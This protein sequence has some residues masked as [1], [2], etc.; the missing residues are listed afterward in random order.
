MQLDELRGALQ[1][2]A[3]ARGA[4]REACPDLDR[5]RATADLSL[6]PNERAAAL[7]HVAQCAAC[8]R[9][10]DTLRT[11]FVS[12]DQLQRQAWWLR[13]SVPLAA[14]AA[15]VIAIG[16][17]L[18]QRSEQQTVRGTPSNELQIVAPSSDP[19][20]NF[21]RRLVWRSIAPDAS[22][23]VVLLRDGLPLINYAGLSDTTVVIADSVRLDPPARFEWFVEAVRGSTRV[24]S[25]VQSFT[26]PR[27]R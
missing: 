21:D 12:H 27:A 2:L 15:I 26:L 6:S 8:R 17:T 11:L 1:R 22:Y 13:R 14:A 25:R 10:F 4:A 23:S 19:G 9:E 20:E 24:R 16:V 5:L 7:D 18:W 3:A